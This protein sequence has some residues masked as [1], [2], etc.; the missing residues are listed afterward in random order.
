M[1]TCF[2]FLVINYQT[3]HFH[4]NDLVHC[5]KSTGRDKL[6][7]LRNYNSM[8]FTQFIACQFGHYRCDVQTASLLLC[9][10]QG[11]AGALAGEGSVHSG[12]GVELLAD[13]IS[14][15]ELN[16]DLLVAV[17]L[18]AGA[19]GADVGWVDNIGHDCIVDCG[20]GAGARADLQRRSGSEGSHKKANS[21]NDWVPVKRQNAENTLYAD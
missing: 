4:H 18:V 5:G 19:L 14:V 20:E 6:L 3:K 10:R 11:E 1:S 21:T 12:E 9:G 7:K 2:Q 16:F 17:H 8:L 15:F 13:F